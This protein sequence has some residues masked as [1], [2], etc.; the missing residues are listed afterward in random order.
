MPNLK[1]D[2]YKKSVRK[3][4]SDL[5][6][7]WKEGEAFKRYRKEP[8]LSQ[9]LFFDLSRF[10]PSINYLQ[11]TPDIFISSD[12]IP[13][14]T[15]SPG[16]I[17]GLCHSSRAHLCSYIL[18]MIYGQCLSY[19]DL[20]R[21]ADHKLHCYLICPQNIILE[22]ANNKVFNIEDMF[23]NIIASNCQ[24]YLDVMNLHSIEFEAPNFQKAVCCDK[25]VKFEIGTQF[26]G[27]KIKFKPNNSFQQTAR[28][29][30]VL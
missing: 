19:A 10:K 30:P 18:Q 13:F 7:E 28:A 4:L 15:K 26:L 8:L 20:F 17:Y 21:L 2:E 9:D 25:Y 14:E 12:N 6:V 11:H 5:G 22:K 3:A 16:E 27:T 24:L 1:A 23:R 29:V